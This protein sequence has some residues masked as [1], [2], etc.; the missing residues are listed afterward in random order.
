MLC[1]I[2]NRPSSHFLSNAW[3]SKR[4]CSDANLPLFPGPQSSILRVKSSG[5]GAVR[6][7]RTVRV[8]EVVGSNPAAP[9]LTLADAGVF[10]ILFQSSI[11]T[12]EPK[13]NA[14]SLERFQL[15]LCDCLRLRPA[16]AERFR[17][18]AAEVIETAI[19]MGGDYQFNDFKPCGPVLIELGFECLNILA[20]RSHLKSLNKA[21]IV[22]KWR[23]NRTPSDISDEEWALLEPMIPPAKNRWSSP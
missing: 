16:L 19:Q 23:E 13:K 20:L 9:T 18:F 3:G 8:G 17:M 11:A 15:P 5:R 10:L 1:P 22:V 6:L 12:R 2:L 21:I 14:P 7:A 4:D